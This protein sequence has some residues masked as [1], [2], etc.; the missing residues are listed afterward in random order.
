MDKN[1]VYETVGYVG[2]VLVAVSLTMSS[3]VRLRVINLVGAACFATY[4]GLIGSL[5]VLALDGFIAVVDVYFLVRIF[6]ARTY[7]KLLEM[8][9]PSDYFHYFLEH[10]AAGIREAQPGFAFEQTPTTLIFFVLRDMLPVG[11]FIGDVR[12]GGALEVRLDFVIPGY[13]DLKNGRFLFRDQADFFRA[14]GIRRIVS[15]PGS[16]EHVRYLRKMGFAPENPSDPASRY[17]RDV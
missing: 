17:V 3:I 10:H 14:R 4:G 13:R 5:P 1:W 11:L 16:A 6:G 2:S 12:D 8:Q 15:A 9:R 7:F